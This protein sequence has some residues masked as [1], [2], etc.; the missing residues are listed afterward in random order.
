MDF[1]FN[2]YVS[3]C[4]ALGI[5]ARS[6]T[7][8]NSAHDTNGSVMIETYFKMDGS[9]DEWKNSDSVWLVNSL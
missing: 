6:V 7:N 4:R 2:F 8:F 9:P 3:V 1:I 5:P